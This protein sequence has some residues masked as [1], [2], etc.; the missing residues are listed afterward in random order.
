M[1]DNAVKAYYTEAGTY[2]E[3]IAPKT[4][5]A[6]CVTIIRT[7]GITIKDAKISGDLIVAEGV[8]EGDFTLDS[9]TVEGKLIARGGGENSIHIINGAEVNGRV[10]IERID[11]V[12]RI[13]SD[14]KVIAEL[15]ANEDVILEG[16]FTK[17]TVGE[18][19]SVEV[20]GQVDRLDVKAKSTLKVTKDGSIGTLDIEKAAEGTNLEMD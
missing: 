6:N 2:T 1:I 14:G 12:V 20:R 10:S 8:G 18:G 16:E 7:T 11:G 9:T 15:D 13:V 5:G 17:V 4:T 19:A 3:N